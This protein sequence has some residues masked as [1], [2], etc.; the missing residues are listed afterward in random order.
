MRG[1]WFFNPLILQTFASIF[2]HTVG[3]APPSFPEIGHPIA[4]L[5]LACVSV[6]FIYVL[7]SSL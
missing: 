7:L 3:K 2:K 4:A 1:K 6:C 5:A